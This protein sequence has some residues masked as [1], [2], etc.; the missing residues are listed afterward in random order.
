MSYLR[1]NHRKCSLCRGTMKRKW[2]ESWDDV[3]IKHY[4]EHHGDFLTVLTW[5]LMDENHLSAQTS[6]EAPDR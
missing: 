2:G 1:E 4:R 3:Y 5:L 6:K